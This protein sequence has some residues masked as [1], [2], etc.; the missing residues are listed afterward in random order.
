MDVLSYLILNQTCL[1][2]GNSCSFLI[3]NC[4]HNNVLE[5]ISSTVILW[6][7]ANPPNVTGDS[8]GADD[9]RRTADAQRRG[10]GGRAPVGE[11]GALSPRAA[12]AARA[13]RWGPAHHSRLPSRSSPSRPLPLRPLL[14]CVH[15]HAHWNFLRGRRPPP[16]PCDSKSFRRRIS[17]ILVPLIILLWLR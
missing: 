3:L 6:K 17:V 5:I 12:R 16:R 9:L 11:R 7:L 14:H 13:L 8:G 15:G 10:H 2:C 1:F 4:R